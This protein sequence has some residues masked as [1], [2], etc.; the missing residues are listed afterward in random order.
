VRLSRSPNP[1]VGYGS[2]PHACLGSTHARVLLR[3][4][5]RGLAGRIDRLEPIEGRR[6]ERDIAGL[7]RAHGYEALRVRFR[8][9]AS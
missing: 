9:G 1:H 6:G 4:L 2:G 3:A 8:P 5:L 7:R